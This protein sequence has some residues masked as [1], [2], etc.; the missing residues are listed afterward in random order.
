M[1]Y[2][3]D[4]D[5]CVAPGETLIEWMAA[6][7]ITWQTAASWLKLTR[8]EYDGLLKGDTPITEILAESLERLTMIRSEMWLN[9]EQ[10]F[11]DGIAAGKTQVR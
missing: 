4:P 8:E 3:F 11:R 5:W 9:L 10:R 2:R 6:R 1:N 7:E